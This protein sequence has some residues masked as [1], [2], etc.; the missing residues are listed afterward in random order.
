MSHWLVDSST[1]TGTSPFFK[2]YGV[3][4]ASGHFLGA[5]PFGYGDPQARATYAARTQGAGDGVFADRHDD[6]VV[7]PG[8]GA[9]RIFMAVGDHGYVRYA[10]VVEE[11]PTVPIAPL[12]AAPPPIPAAAP[13]VNPALVGAV[14]GALS[15]SVVGRMAASRNKKTAEAPT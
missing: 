13:T 9:D 3:A 4:H 2:T 10:E 8:R 12:G 7:L 14:A 5:F 11:Q 1:T 15:L 6:I